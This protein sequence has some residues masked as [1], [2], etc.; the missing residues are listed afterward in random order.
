MSADGRTGPGDR[1][2]SVEGDAR[3]IATRLAKL[4]DR[5]MRAAR[6]CELLMT[7]EPAHAAWLLDGLATVGR[8]GG[9]PFEV[10]LL[11]AVD[12][13]SGADLP[14]ETRRAVFEAAAERGLQAC[15]ELL[16]SEADVAID[17][18]HASPRPLR[19]NTRPLTLGER[20]TLAR[21]WDR[22][23]LMR[24]LL[25]PHVEVVKLLL[26]NPHLTESDVLKIATSRRS[27]APVLALIL[28]ADRWS[29]NPRIR[30]ALIRNPALPT[31][32]SLR[33]LG[34]LNRADL[35]E[36]ARDPSLPKAV[37]ASLARRLRPVS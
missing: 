26:G 29:S 10:G 20:K 17:E 27:S 33:L 3:T 11:A 6:L 19:P 5:R 21:S 15:R 34:L 22:E 23:T 36:L 4:P 31:A 32:T 8:G 28:R 24:L 16:L 14:Y 1:V 9:P 7:L 35:R 12:L 13:A 30:M 37:Q 2:Q 25:D 18:G